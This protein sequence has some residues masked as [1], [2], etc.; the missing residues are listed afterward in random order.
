MYNRH[1]SWL[2]RSHLK[3][4]L[5]VYRCVA[6]RYIFLRRNYAPL[7]IIISLSWLQDHSLWP[8]AISLAIPPSAS[9]VKRSL[10]TRA[11][12][13]RRRLLVCFSG[14]TLTLPFTPCFL[15]AIIRPSSSQMNVSPER[16]LIIPSFFS[17]AFAATRI[18]TRATCP[19]GATTEFGCAKFLDDGP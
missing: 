1:A 13:R 2:N 9:D 10:I 16:D 17:G 5:H 8:A 14:Q 18:N 19:N 12:F 6:T 3:S 4:E 11:D 15:S 7:E